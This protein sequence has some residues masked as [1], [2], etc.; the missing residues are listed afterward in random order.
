MLN[1]PVLY[2]PPPSPVLVFLVIV[3]PVK[4]NVPWLFTPPPLALL[5]PV[6]VQPVIVPP[7]MLNVDPELTFT[8]PT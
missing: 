6:A 7:L 1:V 2:T 4:L 5:L 8:P 3:P